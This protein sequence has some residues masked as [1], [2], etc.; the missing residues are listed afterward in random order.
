MQELWLVRDDTY[1]IYDAKPVAEIL[2]IDKQLSAVSVNL[3]EEECADY[4]RVYT[5]Y[6]AWQVKFEKLIAGSDSRT[7]AS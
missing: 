1:V 3:S 4:Y 7:P 5:E 2:G 6:Y